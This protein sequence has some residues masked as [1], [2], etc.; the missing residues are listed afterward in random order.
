MDIA[1]AEQ[2]FACI[3]ADDFTVGEEMLEKLT[4]CCIVRVIEFG[5]KDSPVSDIEVCI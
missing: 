2:Y 4:G 3:Y 1:A 5:K